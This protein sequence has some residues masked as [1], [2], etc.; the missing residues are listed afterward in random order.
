MPIFLYSERARGLMEGFDATIER[1]K[2]P[3]IFWRG[4]NHSSPERV[5]ID[6]LPVFNIYVLSAGIGSHI[7]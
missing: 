2:T 7:A 3:Y 5:T 6:P 1:T 4:D